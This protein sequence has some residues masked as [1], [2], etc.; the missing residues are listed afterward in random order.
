MTSLAE[1]AFGRHCSPRSFGHSGNVGS[2]FAWADPDNGLAA[3]VVFNG[4]VDPDSA[5]L[6]RPAIVRAIV[7]DLGLDDAPRPP[8]GEDDEAEEPPRR[9]WFRRG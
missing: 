8:Q 7:T 4:V 2:S 5:F 1:H 9:R 6:R 3:A